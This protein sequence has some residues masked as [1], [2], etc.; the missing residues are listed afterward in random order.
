MLRRPPRRLS[1]TNLFHF[2]GKQVSLSLS[3]SLVRSTGIPNISLPPLRRLLGVRRIVP[4]PP[5]ARSQ[6]GHS[7][8]CFLPAGEHFTEGYFSLFHVHRKT[9]VV[10]LTGV[11]YAPQSATRHTARHFVN[12]RLRH[13]PAGPLSPTCSRCAPA[14]CKNTFCMSSIYQV[15][16]APNAQ[17]P[18]YFS[19][20]CRICKTST[21][22]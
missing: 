16:G 9:T 7:V 6:C 13:S 19:I 5:C 8:K 2:I 14:D 4:E 11:I 15:S 18:F 21:H 1:I 12:T 3:P 10:I 20:A 17:A 22:P